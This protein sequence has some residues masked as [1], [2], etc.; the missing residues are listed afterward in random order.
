MYVKTVILKEITKNNYYRLSESYR[1]AILKFLTAVVLKTQVFRT[2]MQ[3]RLVNS[4]CPF[5]ARNACI[6]GVGIY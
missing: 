4:C 2:L 1:R 6:F 5:K 3:C